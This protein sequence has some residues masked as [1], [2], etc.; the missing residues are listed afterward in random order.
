MGFGVADIL[1]PRETM[2]LSLRLPLLSA[3]VCMAIACGGVASTV[4]ASS[5]SSGGLDPDGGGI[6][7]DGGG[8]AFTSSGHIDPSGF[9]ATCSKGLAGLVPV[10]PFDA[11][12]IRVT[13]EPLDDGGVAPYTVQE[14]RGTPCL[15]AKDKNTCKAAFAAATITTSAW[16][17]NAGYQ[18]GVAPPPDRYAFYVVTRSDAVVVIATSADL[19]TFIAPIDTLTEAIHMRSGP[20]GGVSVCPRVRTDADGY[21]FLDDGCGPF[22]DNTYTK[23]EI[24]TK[25]SRDGSIARTQTAGPFPDPTL[26]CA[27]AP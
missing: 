7:R 25:V 3:L 13:A 4:G 14:T 26:S 19:A 20:L 10:G 11:I 18:G 15:N 5:S 23:T 24:V 12:E 6:D 9:P 27:P 17:T 1:L 2:T 21:S 8:D 16:S 22:N